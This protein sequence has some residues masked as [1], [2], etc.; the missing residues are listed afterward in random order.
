MVRE[1]KSQLS[2][3]DPVNAARYQSNA[4]KTEA[5]LDEL[6]TEIEA[7]LTG[8]QAENSLPFMTRISTLRTVSVSGRSV[9]LP[10]PPR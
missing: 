10:Y 3:I 8:L 9:L 6:V 7:E 2:S 1:I 4:K 5:K